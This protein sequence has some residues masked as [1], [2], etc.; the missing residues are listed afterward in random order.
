M[1]S[2]QVAGCAASTIPVFGVVMNLVVTTKLPLLDCHRQS[3][4][5]VV[6]D[7]CTPSVIPANYSSVKGTGIPI[8][9]R[10]VRWILGDSELDILERCFFL[11]F[12]LPV[13]SND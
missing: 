3:T 8:W 6:T 4:P 2:R 7:K 12:L 13:V 10:L 9:L 1:R 5:L 11:M